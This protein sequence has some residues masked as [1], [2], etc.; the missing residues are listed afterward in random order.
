MSRIPGYEAAMAVSMLAVTAGKRNLLPWETNPW[1]RKILGNDD[2][3]EIKRPRLSMITEVESSATSSGSARQ[4]D[5]I[6]PK[7]SSSAISKVSPLTSHLGASD[8]EPDRQKANEAWLL[9]LKIDLSESMVGRQ[10]ERILKEN[11][12][13]LEQQ[14]EV[15]ETLTCTTRSKSVNTLMQRA[16]CISQFLNWLKNPSSGNGLPI[17]GKQVFD[18]LRSDFM[19]TRG[20]TTGTRLLESLAFAAAIF[21]VNGAASASTSSRTKGAALDRFLQK[22]PRCPAQALT[23]LQLYSLEVFWPMLQTLHMNE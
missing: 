2:S 14:H 10:I 11:I 4:V 9:I 18:Y 22:A 6:E 20:A 13:A 8:P 3:S 12:G 21:G 7:P 16:C 1:L 23:D 19:K 15:S 17:N 5:S